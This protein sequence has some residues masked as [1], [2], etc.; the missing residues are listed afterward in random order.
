M[1]KEEAEKILLKYNISRKQLPRVKIN[2]AA[3]ENLQCEIGDVIEITRK[4]EIYGDIKFYRV[5]TK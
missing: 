4:S 3:I 5:V 1:A 2:D